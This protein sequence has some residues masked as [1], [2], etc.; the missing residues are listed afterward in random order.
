MKIRMNFVF[1]FEIAAVILARIQIRQRN[2]PKSD[3]SN[4]IER[5][6][7]TQSHSESEYE[8]LKLPG[9]TYCLALELG[10]R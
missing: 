1:S 2:I 8:P 5:Q 4:I 9:H 10:Q 7:H 3:V 6:N